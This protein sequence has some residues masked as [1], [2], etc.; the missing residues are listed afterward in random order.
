M[1]KK[2]QGIPLK[3]P[4]KTPEK[5]IEALIKAESGDTAP[6]E[7]AGIDSGTDSSLRSDIAY[8]KKIP[9][10]IEIWYLEFMSPISLQCPAVL[11]R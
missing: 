11:R 3:A 6:S 8:T 5:Y 2:K 9:K 4:S 7:T 1:S 10:N